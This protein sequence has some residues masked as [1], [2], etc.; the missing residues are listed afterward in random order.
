MSIWFD[1]RTPGGYSEYLALL[2]ADPA[3]KEAFPLQQERLNWQ[4][5]M[6][7][8]TGGNRSVATL[9]PVSNR[10]RIICALYTKTAREGVSDDDSYHLRVYETWGYLNQSLARAFRRLDIAFREP[11]LLGR[12]DRICTLP[13]QVQGA[14]FRILRGVARGFFKG[15]LT[16][17]EL[18]VRLRNL[19]TS[20]LG[21]EALRQT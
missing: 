3:S 16:A 13:Q 18:D 19:A 5:D 9:A 6:L 10:G 12:H 2:G 14:A 21:P 4:Y 7:L 20:L 17:A 11:F 8:Y 15:H 1:C